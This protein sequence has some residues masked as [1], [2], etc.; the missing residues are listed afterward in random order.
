M[1]KTDGG[2]PSAKD[3]CWPDDPEAYRYNPRLHSARSTDSYLFN[4][5]IPYIG[6]KRKLLPLIY[7]AIASTGVRGGTFLDAFS[8][9]GV[10]SRLAKLLG[11][12]VVSNDWEPY[13]LNINRS[14]VGCNRPPAF[15]RLGG[16]QRA[17][18]LLDGLEPVD[19]YVARHFCPADDSDPRPARERMFFTRANG[20]RIDAAR[21]AIEAWAADGLIND[22]ERSFLLGPLLYSVSY[23][24]NTSGVFKAYHNGWGGATGTA[25]YRILSRMETTPPV[26]FDNGMENIVLCE[27]AHSV[28]AAVDADITYID[29]PY[30]QH[31]YGSNYHLLNTV[32]VWDKPAL[33]PSVLVGG[34]THN[35]SA[36]RRDW[37]ASRRSRF[38]TRGA[39][40]EEM[41]RVLEESRSGYV[42]I[43]Y[44]T[45]GIIPAESLIRLAAGFGE[46]ELLTARYK[47]YRVSSQR[48]SEKPM[49][50]EFVVVL[51][52]TGRRCEPGA[53][54][55]RLRAESLL[56]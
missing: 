51:R 18:A 41:G 11:F 37:R 30:N 26:L 29:P 8:G 20:A 12:R 6:N 28:V 2:L 22:A 25:L 21:D 56:D 31:Q 50:V 10:V 24:S 55:R 23:V 9:S 1:Q 27:D 38:C 34:R 46:V 13:S 49:T 39:A 35:K 43:S 53:A 45:D 3:T 47:R 54:L 33:N 52:R 17:F 40:E 36:I 4:Q 44:S 48:Y 7:G 19:G 16:A 32:A 42:L 15:K 5:L 14:F